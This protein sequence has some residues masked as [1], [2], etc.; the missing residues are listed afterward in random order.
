MVGQELD[1]FRRE[2]RAAESTL[3]SIP[4]T[5]WAEPGLGEWTL[6]ELVAH[7]VGVA[8]RLDAF[9]Q[10]AGVADDPPDIDRYHYFR[11]SARP[12]LEARVVARDVAHGVDPATWPERLRAACDASVRRFIQ[13]GADAIVV[14]PWGLMIAQEYLATRVLEVM[15]HHRDV[16]VAAGCDPA[17]TESA[18]SI[19][20]DLLEG[21]L[22]GPPPPLDVDSFIAAATGRVPSDDKRFPLL[23]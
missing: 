1:A 12:S 14:T 4:E 18:A 13:I 22:E 23:R 5:A 3:E 2:C 15:V 16:C 19:T 20:K 10:Q 21:M 11:S 8:G 6:H 17:Y 7:L 9:V